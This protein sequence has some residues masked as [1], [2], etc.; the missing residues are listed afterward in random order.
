MTQYL[1]ANW[2]DFSAV[3]W[4]TAVISIILIGISKAGFGGGV[5]VIATPLLAL[6]MPVAAAA[7]LLLPILITADIFTVYYYRDQFDRSIIKLLLPGAI[8]GIVLGSLFFN[9]FSQN[10]ALIKVGIG[11]VSIL[12]VLY[13]WGKVLLFR[14]FENNPPGER[15]GVALATAAGFT[16]TIAHVGGPPIAIYL[17]PQDL[18]RNVFVGTTAVFFFVVNVIKLI[19]YSILGLL[20]V[21]NLIATLL[22]IP[23]AFIGVQ[24]GKW[25]NNKVN[26]TW[27]NRIVYTLLLLT[28]IQL[29][30]GVSFINLLF[31]F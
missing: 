17:L 19:P 16:S 25:M 4:I 26:Q 14:S 12:F 27:F 18:S 15:A 24:L 7:A 6:T 22:L 8:V 13:Q 1:V 30:T 21:G 9:L 23:V 3:V 2:P 5:G 31:R 28:G 29:V 11:V 10:E 20:N